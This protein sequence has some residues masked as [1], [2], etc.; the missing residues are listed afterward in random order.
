MKPCRNH[1]VFMYVVSLVFGNV[2]VVLSGLC[3]RLDEM[4]MTTGLSSESS[5]V[6]APGSKLGSDQRLSVVPPA[7]CRTTKNPWK[8]C[9]DHLAAVGSCEVVRCGMLGMGR[10]YHLHHGLIGSFGMGTAGC[11]SSGN[12]KAAAV[13]SWENDQIIPQISSF[14]LLLWSFIDKIE[15]SASEA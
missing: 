15:I 2:W 12:K 5:S 4:A 7:D 11:T 1:F 14:E 13:S 8:R 10:S 9:W 3:S 6:L